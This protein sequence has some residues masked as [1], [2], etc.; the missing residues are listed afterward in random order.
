MKPEIKKSLTQAFQNQIKRLMDEGV[1]G[2]YMTT[3]LVEVD[4]VQWAQARQLI[5]ASAPL[6]QMEKLREELEELQDAL[7][8]FQ[9]YDPVKDAAGDEDHQKA[10]PNIADAIGDMGV[11]LTII[12]A[13]LGM[14]F[15]DCLLD[16]YTEIA[17]RKG[18]TV[19]GIFHKNLYVEEG[20]SDEPGRCY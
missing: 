4:I 19:D 10:I 11:V 13:Q 14:S 1:V 15:N 3:N 20:G 6:V 18:T 9:T 5:S 12:A 7:E 8:F 17:D 16:A 2:S